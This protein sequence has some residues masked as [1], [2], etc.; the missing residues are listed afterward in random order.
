MVLPWPGLAWRRRAPACAAV[1][2]MAALFSS[3]PGKCAS[4]P[5][6][7]L[8]L[9]FFHL[10]TCCCGVLAYA[11]TAVFFCSAMFACSCY[12]MLLR[13]ACATAQDC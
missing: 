6:P 4:F 13:Y 12:A 2:A 5:A 10:Q 8:C 9:T 1:A 11:S 7:L 3:T